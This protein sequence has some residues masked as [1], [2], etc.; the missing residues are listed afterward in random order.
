MLATPAYDTYIS[1]TQQTSN[2]STGATNKV[3]FWFKSHQEYNSILEF[4]LSSLIGTG[5][6]SAEFTFFISN[7]ERASGAQGVYNLKRI[8]Q[9]DV[10][11]TKCTWLIYDDELDP[12]DNDWITPGAGSGDYTEEGS[13]TWDVQDLNDS[14]F[15]PPVTKTIT[16]LKTIVQD[17]IT[18]NNGRLLLLMRFD[19]SP[20]AEIVT[21]YSDNYVGSYAPFLDIVIT[22]VSRKQILV[23]PVWVDR[24]QHQGSLVTTAL[25]TSWTQESGTF[26][27][28]SE[29]YM[30]VTSPGEISYSGT[31]LDQLRT[32]TTGSANY[33]LSLYFRGQ[34]NMKFEIRGRWAD[35][36]NYV[37]LTIDFE[38][39]EVQLVS[40]TAGVLADS[41]PVVS[42][43]FKEDAPYSVELIMYGVVSIAFI[44]G[45][46]V[47]TTTMGGK[48]TNHGFSIYVEEA[49]ETYPIIF[50]AFAAFEVEEY[51]EESLEDQTSNLLLQ[52]RKSIQERL[53]NPSSKTWDTYREARKIWRYQRN[54][55]HTHRAWI[56]LGY[57]I[58]DP[59]SEEWFITP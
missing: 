30:K 25:P 59:A 44:N 39:N 3:G 13:I 15:D 20:D 46:I 11:L 1:Y 54:Q 56:A 22:N 26:S 49:T 7:I 35:S 36:N 17:A 50:N 2:F 8:T 29:H 10:D 43:S 47:D 40:Y 52:S 6:V 58:H 33:A 32:R 16:G 28:L 55:G 37:A 14:A 45:S 34:E 21:Y 31:S 12:P 51:P 9:N 23:P 42:H 38:N 41:S 4:D 24:F 48:L 57:P 27:T 53:E 5:V 19:P 18:N